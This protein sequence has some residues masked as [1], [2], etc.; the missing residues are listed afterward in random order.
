MSDKVRV[1]LIDAGEVIRS[2]RAMLIN[3]QSN[4][5]VVFES[6]DPMGSIETTVEY[7]LDVVIVDARVPGADLATYLDRL[8][9]ALLE[10]QN[11][12]RVIVSTTFESAELNLLAYESGASATCAQDLGAAE[13]L[14]TVRAVASG[15]AALHRDELQTLIDSSSLSIA[16]NPSLVAAYNRMDEGQK[17]VV[18]ALLEGLTDSQIANKLD[19]TKYRVTKFLDALC[20]SLGFLTRVQLELGIIRAGF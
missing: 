8:G 16:P 2:G 18:A 12:V 17:R 4:L 9:K 6:G 3:S 20:Q 10:A 19:L 11:P 14:E 7:L 1:G 15:T 13:L 5:Q